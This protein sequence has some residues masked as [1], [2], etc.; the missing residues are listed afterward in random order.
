ME[1]VSAVQEA[2]TK[3][4]QS[5]LLMLLE[6]KKTLSDEQTK[7]LD[8]LRRDMINHMREMGMSPGGHMGG[9]GARER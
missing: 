8:R 4:E 7:T 2:R 5:R 6:I 9:M 1:M 3:L